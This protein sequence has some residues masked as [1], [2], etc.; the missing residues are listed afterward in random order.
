VGCKRVQECARRRESKR[1]KMVCVRQMVQDGARRVW[2]P[3]GGSRQCDT[4]R[5]ARAYYIS[6]KKEKE[7][8]ERCT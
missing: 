8:T 5:A 4:L 6:R 7:G 2:Q 3:A 1:C